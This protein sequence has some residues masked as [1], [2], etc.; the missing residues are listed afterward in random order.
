MFAFSLDTKEETEIIT[1]INDVRN[2]ESNKNNI[3]YRKLR[4]INVL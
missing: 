1:Y 3:G 2:I 4:L